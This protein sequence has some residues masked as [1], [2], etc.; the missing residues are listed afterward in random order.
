LVFWQVVASV[1]VGS[2]GLPLGQ[3]EL[4]LL[5]VPKIRG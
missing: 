2:V 4:L 1:V 5:G 3:L